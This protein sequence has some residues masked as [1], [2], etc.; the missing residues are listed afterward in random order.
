M[1]AGTG[2]TV[3]T[4]SGESLAEAPGGGPAGAAASVGAVAEQAASTILTAKISAGIGVFMRMGISCSV[5]LRFVLLRCV[6]G[7]IRFNAS[8]AATGIIDK[9]SA[10]QPYATFQQ[11]QAQA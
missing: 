7:L 6:S 1:N 11:P 8:I 2:L 10:A 4:I 3:P 5:A 9:G